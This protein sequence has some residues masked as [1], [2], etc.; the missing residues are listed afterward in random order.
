MRVWLRKAEGASGLT[1]GLLLGLVSVAAIIAVTDA[2][3]SV[4][5]LFEE[6]ATALRG[7]Q[8]CPAGDIDTRVGSLSHGTLQHR[9]GASLVLETLPGQPANGTTRQILPLICRDGELSVGTETSQIVCDTRFALHDSSCVDT[10]TPPAA[11]DDALATDADTGIADADLLANDTDAD[12]NSLT[13]TAV[14]GQAVNVGQTLTLASGAHVTVTAAGLLSYAPNGAFDSLAGGA[15]GTDSLTYTASDGYAEATATVSV[16]V[17]GVNDAPN[18]VADS[19]ITDEATQLNSGNVLANDTDPNQT[20]ILTVVAINGV[21]EDVGRSFN[22]P[23]GAVLQINAD[24]ALVLY[25]PN[26]QYEHLAAGETATDSFAYSLSDGTTTVDATVTV[27][28]NGVNDVPSFSGTIPTIVTYDGLAFAP[29]QAGALFS[30]ADINDSVTYEQVGTWPR[31][32]N[33]NGSTGEISG[34]AEH[35]EVIAGVRVRRVDGQNAEALSNFFTVEVQAMDCQD[36]ADAGEDQN[37]TYDVDPDGPGPAT[38]R[39]VT[40]DFGGPIAGAGWVQIFDRNS[41]DPTFFVSSSINDLGLQYNQLRIESGPDYLLDYLVQPGSTPNE[42]LIWINTAYNIDAQV[43]LIDGENGEQYAFSE[44][45]TGR[46]RGGGSNTSAGLSEGS[47]DDGT[48]FLEPVNF[49]PGS[50]VFIPTAYF[51]LVDTAGL[52]SRLGNPHEYR[53]RAYQDGDECALSVVVTLP[54][55]LSGRITGIS[56]IESLEHLRDA[57]SPSNAIVQDFTIYARATND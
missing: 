51:L 21:P 23:S 50:V 34:T 14:E 1:Y 27:T 38:E 46:Q 26:G 32:L 36:W 41:G 47:S 20:D 3:V 17:T 4:R 39:G 31:W 29:F 44:D 33:L 35:P 37:G 24:G 19:F 45:P 16:T 15:T 56:D 12:G 6:T 30:D 52:T 49:P 8:S 10:N 57:Y 7:G 18:A 48:W 2:G 9:S 28:I 25:R 53:P 43:F 40:C 55:E 11:V 54:D 5:S 22:L 42:N 13:V